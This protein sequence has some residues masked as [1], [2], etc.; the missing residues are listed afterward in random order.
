MTSVEQGEL[1]GLQRVRAH[2]SRRRAVKRRVS[3]AASV[4]VELRLRAAQTN[5]VREGADADA[6]ERVGVAAGGDDDD[7]DDDDDDDE[8]EED[9]KDDDAVD[10]DSGEAKSGDQAA[11]SASG[12]GAKKAKTTARSLDPRVAE[13]VHYLYEE[14]TGALTK[15]V[16]VEITSRGM[17][18]PLGVLSPSQLDKGE[19]VLD[20][21]EQALQT[22]GSS[23]ASRL[24][25]LSRF[26]F[27]FVC[28][29]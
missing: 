19:A 14:A 6:K 26:V 13:F 12:G 10:E 8:E 29:T 2:P 15:V 9:D 24:Q 3:R 18:T 20:K 1:C 21:I 7:E 27:I 23:M 16:Q 25:A 17:K 11:A 5:A 28:T 22:G 4:G